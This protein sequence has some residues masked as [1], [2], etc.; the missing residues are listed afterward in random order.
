LTHGVRQAPD[1]DALATST[2]GQASVLLWNYHD[3]DVAAPGNDI[4]VTLKSIPS[5]ASRVLLQQYR[6][7]DHHSNAYSVWKEMG[8]PQNPTPEQYAKLQAA[9]QLQL[10][11][12]PRWMAPENGTIQ[13]N[14]QLP[15]MGLSLLRVTWQ[16]N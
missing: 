2:P 1:I 7:D 4:V 8:E 14:V 3:D 15:R 11:D 10:L 16:T 12:S 6:I 5:S 13:V 9:G